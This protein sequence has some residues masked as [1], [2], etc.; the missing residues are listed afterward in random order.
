MA[1]LTVHS[2]LCRSIFNYSNFLLSFKGRVCVE[3]RSGSSVTLPDI[4]GFC[5]YGFKKNRE[6]H[7]QCIA[8]ITME[9]MLNVSLFI[10]VVYQVIH[11]SHQLEGLKV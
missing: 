1:F 3:S 5:T 2:P 4:D 10:E 6:V 11:D 7:V 8:N 9:N